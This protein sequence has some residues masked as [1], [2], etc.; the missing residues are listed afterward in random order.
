MFLDDTLTLCDD[1]S[2]NLDLLVHFLGGGVLIHFPHEVSGES[3]RFKS[4]RPVG[5]GA[6][7]GGTDRGS[8]CKQPHYHT[9][10]AA[11][12]AV[13]TKQCAAAKA[14][15]PGGERESG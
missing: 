11:G 12:G 10:T 14:C 6:G 1:G 13:Q 7:R 2:Q 8:L 9:L 4:A 5:F 15:L 3:F